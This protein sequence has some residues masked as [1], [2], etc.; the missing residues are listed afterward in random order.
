MSI[1]AFSSVSESGGRPGCPRI[2]ATDI[3]TLHFT[4]TQVLEEQ[5]LGFAA[6]HLQR[7]VVRHNHTKKAARTSFYRHSGSVIMLIERIL[8]W[9][10][11]RNLPAAADAVGSAAHALSRPA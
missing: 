11:G 2:E 10:D 4:G 7:T 9:R 6:L 8:L 3:L 1:F 5:M